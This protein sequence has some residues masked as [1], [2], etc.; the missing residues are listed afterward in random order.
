MEMIRTIY[1]I[2]LAYF[3]AGAIAFFFINRKKSKKEA[4][5]NRTKFLAY[6]III[7]VLFFGIVLEP[8][9][10]R[11]L[12]LLILLAGIL[13][14][15]S[16]FRKSGFQK[17]RFFVFS[18]F[19]FLVL[20]TGFFRFSGLEMEVILF[21][22]IL[23]SVFDS[24]SQIAGQLWGKRKIIPKVSA[25]KTL[26]GLIGGALVTFLTAVLLRKLISES[27]ISLLVLT[28]GIVFFAFAGDFLA[29]YYKRNFQV[30][31]FSRLIPGHGGFLDR[32]DSLIAGGAW[33][34]LA[35][36]IFWL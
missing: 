6:F 11:F 14:M 2:I 32:F 3:V 12:A 30:K 31:D 36:W 22:F 17:R 26:E 10:F 7:H 4:S 25:G 23:L 19:I 9:V 16:L 13:E 18:V 20:G 28:A 15:I 27:L 35:G 5:K 29:S 1:T 8:I 33:M 24:F 34:A 21:A